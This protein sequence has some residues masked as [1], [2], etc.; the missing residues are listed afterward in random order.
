MDGDTVDKVIK[1]AGMIMFGVIVPAAWA[2][3]L[4]R[5]GKKGSPIRTKETDRNVTK[6]KLHIVKKDCD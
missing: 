4:Y 2:Y 3:E 6:A 1:V 5:V